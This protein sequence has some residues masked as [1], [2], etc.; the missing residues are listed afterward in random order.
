MSGILFCGEFGWDIDP[1]E[2][3]RCCVSES[4]SSDALIF[5]NIGGVHEYKEAG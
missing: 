5:N 1:S 2:V 3:L 4:V